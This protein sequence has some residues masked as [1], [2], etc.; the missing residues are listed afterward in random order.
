MKAKILVEIELNDE[1]VEKWNKNFQD[2]HTDLYKSEEKG[3][4]AL[5]ENPIEKGIASQIEDWVYNYQD[6][7]VNCKATVIRKNDI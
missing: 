2:Y 3:K 7:I 4:K 5:E 1:Y 6:G